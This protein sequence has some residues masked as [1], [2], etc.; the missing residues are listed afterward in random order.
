M[1]PRYHF[2]FIILRKKILP[3]DK[4]KRVNKHY[5]LLKP[6]LYNLKKK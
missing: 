2:K 4:I 1:N 5:L 3:L 6:F